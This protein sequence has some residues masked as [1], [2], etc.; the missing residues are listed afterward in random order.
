MSSRAT[1]I[2]LNGKRYDARTGKMLSAHETV[3]GTKKAYVKPATKQSGVA[4][5]GFSRRKAPVSERSKTTG[6]TVSS[7]TE[8]SKTLMRSVVKKPAVKPTAT[9]PTVSRRGQT[10]RLDIDPK[11]VSRAKSVKQSNLVSKYGVPKK[12]IT[13]ITTTLPVR[14][15]PEA[16]PMFAAHRKPVVEDK[17][18]HSKKFQKAIDNATSHAQPRAKKPSKRQNISKKLRI[19]NRTVNFAAVSLAVVLLGGFIAY[20]N[21]PNL[22]MRVA[23]T[24][25][26]VEGRLPGYHPSGFG[27]SGPIKYQQGQITLN[28]SSNSDDRKFQVNQAASQWNSDSLAENY[29]VSANKTYQIFQD[30]GRQIYIYDDNNAT[31]VDGGIWYK[32]EGNSALNNDQ[33]LRMAA[34]L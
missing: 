30:G 22:S 32:I 34:S 23:A 6:R 27:L 2:E 26:G 19:S 18:D 8:K 25:A 28:Y 4:L 15:E 5:D 20:Q 11:R 24:R 29:L 33:L 21:V 14:P 31:W 10:P 17:I 16:P 12:A 13:P 1:T 7:K 3:T 9:K